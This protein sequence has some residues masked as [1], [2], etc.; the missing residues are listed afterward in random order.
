MSGNITSLLDKVKENP[1]LLDA[2]YQWATA[3]TGSTAV[4]THG[5]PPNHGLIKSNIMSRYDL[6]E[7]KAGEIY[8]E[9]IK[10]IESTGFNFDSGFLEAENEV[11]K[12]FDT[13]DILKDTVLQRLKSAK[14]KEKYIVWFFCKIK[15]NYDIWS[16][17][18]GA[19]NINWKYPHKISNKFEA[20]LNITFN[21]CA[22]MSE[23]SDLLIKLGFLNKLEWV[24][25]R[26]KSDPGKRENELKFPQY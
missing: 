8:N 1:I 5:V 20:L 21:S 18:P 4:H 17:S 12:Y 2:I 16:E 11:I 6:T 25:S 22:T 14:D 9:L 15:D 7:E 3:P 19:Y 26:I 13:N 24:G 10:E 23:V